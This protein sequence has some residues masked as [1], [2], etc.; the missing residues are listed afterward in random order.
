MLILPA[1]VS[2]QAPSQMGFRSP[3]VLMKLGFDMREHY[4]ELLNE[5]IPDELMRHLRVIAAQES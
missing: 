3:F 4:D 5:P 1:L 2:F